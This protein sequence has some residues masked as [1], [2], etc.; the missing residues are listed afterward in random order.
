MLAPGVLDQPG[1]LFAS[2]G[3]ET[4]DM[5]AARVGAW[6]RELDETDG[7]R[8]IVVSHG[9][10]GSVL[11]ELYGGGPAEQTRPPQD[12]VF[13]LYGGVVGRVDEGAEADA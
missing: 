8:R 1:W 4:Y 2:P 7:R 9:V 3:G 6:L 11:R 12:A 13:L 5:V 10:A